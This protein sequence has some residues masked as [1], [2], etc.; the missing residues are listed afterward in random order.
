M[1]CKCKWRH[2]ELE[3]VPRSLRKKLA[4]TIAEIVIG[5]RTQAGLVVNVVRRIGEDHVGISA[6]KQPFIGPGAG[7]SPLMTRWSPRIH[8]SPLRE[9]TRG[10]AAGAANSSPSVSES[11]LANR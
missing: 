7:A 3:Q 2:A 11:T 8:S 9:T 6:L 1:T 10:S 5:D 4:K